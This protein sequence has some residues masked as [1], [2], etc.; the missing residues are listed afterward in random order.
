MDR[1]ADAGLGVDDV[2]AL[3]ADVREEH[4]PSGAT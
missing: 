1:A 4:Y 3:Y 2:D